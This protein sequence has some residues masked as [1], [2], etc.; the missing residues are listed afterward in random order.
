MLSL[1]AVVV[2]AL[3]ADRWVLANLE[4]RGLVASESW[5]QHN[6]IVLENHRRKDQFIDFPRPKWTS[7]A[8]V[9]A[10]TGHPVSKEKTKSH[11][12]LVMGDSFVWNS[13]YLTLNHMWWRQLAIELQRRGYNE[14]EVIAAGTSGMSTRDELDLAR[15]VIPEFKPDL[16][17]WGF[18]T[19]DPDERI[20]KQIHN[21]QLSLPIPG[22]IQAILQ[23]TVPRLF[24]LIQSRR[25][26]KLAKLY[27]GPEYGYEYSDWVQRIHAGENF[28]VYEQT[29][30]GVR[31]FLD[32]VN[33]PGLMVTL[34]EAPIA[35]RFSFSYDKV[36]PLWRDAGIPVQDNLVG[37]I[38]R[39]P[40]VGSDGPQALSWGINPADGHPGPRTTAVLAH[41]TADRLEH[42][43]AQFLGPK[44]A[45]NSLIRINDWLPFDL[46][47][48]LIGTG[49]FELTYPATDELLPTMPL[50]I[51]TAL[52]ALEQ[53][54]P[55]SEIRLKGS[56]LRSAQIWI[57]TCDPVEQYDLQDWN[58]QGARSGN[59]IV[60]HLPAGLSSRDTSVVR[61]KAEFS[62]RD[63]HLQ[64][65]FTRTTA[66]NPTTEGPSQP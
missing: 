54:Q 56:H 36:I 53:P 49:Q 38:E 20:I 35:E 29:V 1:I 66:F 39:F 46:N 41:L 65:T 12:I 4:R 60:W 55:L 30:N 8:G 25:S 17:L 18:V 10:W 22:R 2:T 32:E 64:I 52:L 3:I 5:K 28:R 57:S 59:D 43:Y 62:S 45:P 61:L 42:D 11:R 33:L 23:R 6:R 26:D 21:S 19:N 14:V 50:E 37:F 47:V 13:P 27:L 24:D 7:A 51:P 34:P 48:K 63:H 31:Q 44:S 9:R 15:Y 16:I 40:Q 58:D